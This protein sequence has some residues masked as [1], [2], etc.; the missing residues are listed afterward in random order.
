[1]KWEMVSN[2]TARHC[3]GNVSCFR[4][5]GNA[6]NVKNY[7]LDFSTLSVGWGVLITVHWELRATSSLSKYSL[8][9]ALN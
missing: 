7:I 9:M 6:E 8:L 3:P 2:T 4:I 1:M 5:S